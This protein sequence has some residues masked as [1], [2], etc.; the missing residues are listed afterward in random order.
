VRLTGESFRRPL[1]LIRARE[2][3]HPYNNLMAQDFPQAEHADV[4]QGSD[5]H[6]GAGYADNVEEAPAAV[7]YPSHVETNL[8]QNTL[9]NT[10]GAAGTP[11]RGW[12]IEVLFRSLEPR[13]NVRSRKFDTCMKFEIH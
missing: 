4:D 5:L 13:T 3:P 12:H 11:H 10:A 7:E 1:A 6:V 2:Q 9:D 8:E